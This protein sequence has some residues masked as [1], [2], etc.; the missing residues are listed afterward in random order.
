ML[1]PA[2]LYAGLAVAIIR[3]RKKDKE[4]DE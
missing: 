3:N 1:T 4:G 2:I